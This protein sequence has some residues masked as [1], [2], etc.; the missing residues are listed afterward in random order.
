M[1]PENAEI[2]T[3]LNAHI[4]RMIANHGKDEAAKWLFKWGKIRIAE[5]KI[6]EKTVH[7]IVKH[8]AKNFE[9]I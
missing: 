3:R 5:G 6:D 2:I 7:A 8:V 9:L 4:E 1:K